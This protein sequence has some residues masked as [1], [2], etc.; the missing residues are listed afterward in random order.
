M[1]NPYI[2]FEQAKWT[3]SNPGL[4]SDYIEQPYAGMIAVE[5]E[6]AESMEDLST[7]VSMFLD[8]F[9]YEKGDTVTLEAIKREFVSKLAKNN[10]AP[11]SKNQIASR[12][13]PDLYKGLDIDMDAL[14]CIMVDVEKIPVAQYVK[15]AEDDL[16][17]ETK[18]DQDALVGEVKPHVTLLFGLLEN[19]NKWKDKVDTVLDGWKLDTVTI[20]KVSYFDLG[21]SYAVIGLVKATDE[22]VDGH[23]RLT[24]LPHINTFSE[25][26]PHITLAYIKKEADVDKWVKALGKRY[27]GKKVA[28]KGINYGDKDRDSKSKNH[29]EAKE[30][31]ANLLT[32]V[33]SHN[34]AEHHHDTNFTLV[35]A[36]NALD[37]Q[38]RDS[39]L[40]EEAN[41]R[42]AVQKLEA[43][44]AQQVIEA[45]R[46]GD[47]REAERIISEAQEQ[48]LI[49]ELAAILV[50]YYT[51][52]T[53]IYV[54]QLFGTRLAEFGIQAIWGGTGHMEEYIRESAMQAAI[55]H[56]NTSLDAFEKALR[57]KEADV[58]HEGLI[59]DVLSRAQGQQ[60]DVLARLPANPNREDVESAVDK[61][62]F[63]DHPAYARA[64]EL[65]REGAGLDQIIRAITKEFTHIAE[66]RAKVISKHETSRVFNMSQYQADVQFLTEAGLMD[67]AYKKLRSRTGDPCP[68]CAM[69]IAKTEAD[70]IPFT[71]NFAD[72]G[73]KLTANYKK[74]NGTWAVSTL[75]INYEDIVAGN[76][77][78]QCNC[79]YEL[80]VK[81]E[82]GTILNHV[83]YRVNNGLGYNPYRDSKGRF[84]DGLTITA[85]KKMV[86]KTSMWKEFKPNGAADVVTPSAINEYVHSYHKGMPPRDQYNAMNAWVD[87]DGCLDMQ[88]QL[89]TPDEKNLYIQELVDGLDAATNDN[90]IKGTV[91]LYRGM[92][93][94]EADLKELEQQGYFSTDTFFTTALN[95][96]NVEKYFAGHTAGFDSD[97]ND[98]RQPTM[99]RIKAKPG[100]KGIFVD[101]RW[102][103]PDYHN[104]LG[105]FVPSR[106][107]VYKLVNIEYLTSEDG[108][109]RGAL[110][111]LEI[112]NDQVPR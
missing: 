83:D 100:T 91:N 92:A 99:F 26:H 106:K 51:V 36:Q 109:F 56:V 35:K 25:Y 66:L 7:P 54:A 69:L 52:V 21:E 58:I 12:D 18:Y 88:K 89:R 19:G 97:L 32:A 64:R 4:V 72:L 96:P 8:Y 42:N 59:N 47:Q 90:Q 48:S 6:M 30:A 75:P 15:D 80:I 1:I 78:V 84:D 38:I 13:F 9:W 74:E 41:L 111:D 93:T 112:V 87:R 2:D 62:R 5:F 27:D 23:E 43:K 57:A 76:V 105:E 82:D 40:L 61:G 60:A 31:S 95:G 46:Q 77:H 81:Q 17:H 86:P 50:A 85:I 22:I 102:P 16:Y 29:V 3:L 45:L 101:S 68:I 49:Q 55:S 28:T 24:L 103:A 70:P 53:P 65:A 14:G 44:I 79:E 108:E 37:P 10:I 33:L 63:D 34:E 20:D 110:V 39:V 71:S 11:T 107:S 73:T 98:T 67:R 94:T 104:D